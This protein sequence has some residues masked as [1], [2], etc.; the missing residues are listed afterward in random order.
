MSRQYSVSSQENIDLKLE[1]MLDV[2]FVMLIVGIVVAAFL[3]IGSLT[4]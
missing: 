4:I 3:Q 1:L 2:M